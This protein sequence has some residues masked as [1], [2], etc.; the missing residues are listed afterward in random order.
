MPHD[1]AADRDADLVAYYDQEA[2]LRLRRDLGSLRTELRRSFVEL[3]Q[4]EERSTVLDVGAGPGR[5]AIEFAAEGYDV[6]GVDLAPGNVALMAS[7]GIEAH[8]ASLFD[9]P[10]PP[11]RFDAVWTMSTLV[12]VPDARLHEALGSIVSMARPGAPV[13][14]GTWGGFDWEGTSD[15]DTI[16]TNGNAVSKAPTARPA[17]ISRTWALCIIGPVEAQLEGGHGDDDEKQHDG[18]CACVAE[19]VEAESFLVDE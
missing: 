9:L 2:E 18:S 7:E 14:I 13:G 17:P 4:A 16:H 6:T 12:H 1:P 19:L 3:L 8:A 15:V 5:D 11:A 10:F